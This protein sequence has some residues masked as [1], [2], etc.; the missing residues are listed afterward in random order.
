MPNFIPSAF[1]LIRSHYFLL[2]CPLPDPSCKPFQHL[3]YPLPEAAGIGIHATLD[4]NGCVRFGPDTEWILNRRCQSNV[5]DAVNLKQRAYNRLTARMPFPEEDVPYLWDGDSVMD[6]DFS[7]SGSRAEI[8]YESV[9]KYYPG[10]ADDSLEPDYAGIRPKLIGPHQ[11]REILS[12]TSHQSSA[13]GHTLAPESPHNCKKIPK[14]MLTDFC[15]QTPGDHGVPGVYN[16]FGIESPG[17]TSS[18]AIA[19]FVVK[20]VE[21]D[22]LKCL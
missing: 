9:R 8:F 22:M 19:D 15:I 21:K 16:L 5:A 1:F 11:L 20:C 2:Y 17:L 6:T 10:L 14:H 3:I 7:V 13:E 18:M 12:S 4:L